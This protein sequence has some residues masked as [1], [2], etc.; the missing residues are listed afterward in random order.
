MVILYDYRVDMENANIEILFE[1]ENLIALNKPAGILS[2]EGGYDL[3][4]INLRSLLREK[5]GKI[6]VVHRLDRLTSGVILFAKNSN[7]HRILNDQFSNR[8]I[9]KEYR[10]IVHGSPMWREKSVSLPLL[11]DGDRKHRTILEK[12]KGRNAET[13]VKVIAKKD[14]V[15]YLSMM[16]RTGITHQIRAH[17]SLIGLPIIGDELYG[18]F[19]YNEPHSTNNFNYLYLHAY[20]IIFSH[21]ATNILIKIQAD[22]PVH[23]RRKLQ[24]LGF[25]NYC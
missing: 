14:A 7:A 19:F 13:S 23:F 3:Q 10:A 8:T 20:K 16:P 22:F 5:F 9:Y 11:V 17:L 12:D 4:E 2:I 25:C 15:S 6:W 21:P 18:R 24:D 1:D